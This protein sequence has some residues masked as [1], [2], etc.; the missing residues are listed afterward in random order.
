MFSF[1]QFETNLISYDPCAACDSI[2]T[3]LKKGSQIHSVRQNLKTHSALVW[4]FWV[5]P[6]GAASA[7]RPAYSLRRRCKAEGARLGHTAGGR[8]NDDTGLGHSRVPKLF[9]EKS[10]ITST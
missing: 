7:A 4:V 1:R 10:W 8:G 2:T 3:P 9:A 6:P 5:R